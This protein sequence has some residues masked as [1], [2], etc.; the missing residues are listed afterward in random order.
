MLIAAAGAAVLGIAVAVDL[1]SLAIQGNVP[2][3][4]IVAL[5]VVN[6]IGIEYDMYARL[7]TLE[8]K[9]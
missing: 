8:G 7:E 6:H 9:K 2:V 3:L 4:R 5:N 1:D